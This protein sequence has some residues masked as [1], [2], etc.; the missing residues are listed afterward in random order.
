MPAM[1]AFGVA[2]AR[3][4]IIAPKGAEI[5]IRAELYDAS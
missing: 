4:V 2:G 1:D 5:A 3:K